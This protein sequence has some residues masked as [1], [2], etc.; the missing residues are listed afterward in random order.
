[1]RTQ[2]CAKQRGLS[3]TAQRS[4]RRCSGGAGGSESADD[5]VDRVG[6]DAVDVPAGELAM[7]AASFGV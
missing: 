3:P 4:L 7:R 5:V 2:P 1:M 6:D